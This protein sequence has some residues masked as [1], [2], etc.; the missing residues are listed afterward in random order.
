MAVLRANNRVP[1]LQHD[2]HHE[3]NLTELELLESTLKELECGDNNFETHSNIIQIKQRISAIK[4]GTPT[5]L[6]GDK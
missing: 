3:T 5:V 4:N 6:K 2:N 1:G